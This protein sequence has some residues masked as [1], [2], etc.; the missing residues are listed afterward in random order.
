MIKKG[1]TVLIHGATGGVSIYYLLNNRN[2]I[3]FGIYDEL[4]KHPM[5]IVGGP[6]TQNIYAVFRLFFSGGPHL[7]EL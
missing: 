7:V 5:L 4:N 6:L 3:E 1:E 2:K